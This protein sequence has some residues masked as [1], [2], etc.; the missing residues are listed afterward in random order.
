LE[1]GGVG[2]EY[3][4]VLSSG[5]EDSELSVDPEVFGRGGV[6][7][8]FEYDLELRI[9]GNMGR[10]GMGHPSLLTVRRCAGEMVGEDEP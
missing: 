2:V 4:Y 8:D 10:P 6:G 3:E 5:P 1:K 7:V 9:S